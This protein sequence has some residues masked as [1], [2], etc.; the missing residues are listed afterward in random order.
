MGLLG[1][2]GA[3]VLAA[4]AVLRGREKSPPAENQAQINAGF[5]A[6]MERADVTILDMERKER[7]L[8]QYIN[9]LVRIMQERGIEVPSME[10]VLGDK[11]F[12][13]LPAK[14]GHAFDKEN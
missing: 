8:R 6:F 9:L 7:G 10:Q 1:T 13:I 5:I 4:W 12:L 11:E 14:N 3:A 2:V